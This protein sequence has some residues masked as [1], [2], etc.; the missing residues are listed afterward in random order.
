MSLRLCIPLLF[1]QDTTGFGIPSAVQRIMSFSFTAANTSE[2]T[3]IHSGETKTQTISV[4]K[5]PT[6]HVI[7]LEHKH[8]IYIIILL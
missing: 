6:F 8:S 3:V 2:E 7:Y 5:N 1:F 4:L